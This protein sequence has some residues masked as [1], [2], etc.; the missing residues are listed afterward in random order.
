MDFQ[1]LRDMSP[2][3]VAEYSV[4]RPLQRLHTIVRWP[5]HCSSSSLLWNVGFINDIHCWS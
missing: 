5:C 3:T 2:Q 4:E 1:L